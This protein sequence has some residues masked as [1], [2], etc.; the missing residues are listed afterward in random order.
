MTAEICRRCLLFEHNAELALT[1]NEYI[2]ALP[3][4][5]RS[6]DKVYTTRLQV[7]KNCDYL[8]NGMCRLCGCFVEARAAKK[9]SHCA[10][11]ANIW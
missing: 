7:C 10:K 6:D 2:N 5:V 4:K 11:D 1:V 3:N 9:D 8:I